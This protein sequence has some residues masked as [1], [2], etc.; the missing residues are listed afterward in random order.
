M[1]FQVTPESEPM[2]DEQV[3]LWNGRNWMSPFG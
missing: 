3:G 1:I 2:V